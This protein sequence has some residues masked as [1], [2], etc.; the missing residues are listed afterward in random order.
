M[1][2]RPP[3]SLVGEAIL[4]LAVGNA[5]AF[6]G[7]LGDLHEE[8]S[9]SRAAS[10][11][12]RPGA[13]AA[14][15][16]QHAPRP[17]GGLR[18]RRAL[19]A[20]AAG[21]GVDRLRHGSP[22][23]SRRPRDGTTRRRPLAAVGQELGLAARMLRRRPAF[24][25]AVVLTLGLG[26]GAA[27]AVL[28]VAY[29]VWLRPLPFDDPGALVRIYEVK[30][31]D[32]GSV[33]GDGPLR[34]AAL[35]AEVARRSLLSPP[36]V[37]DMR[38]S[39]WD[40]LVSVAAVSSINYDWEHDGTSERL[41]AVHASRGVFDVLG[42]RAI[43]GGFFSD[44]PG[45]REVVLGEGFWRRAFGADPSVV[46]ERTVTLD[47]ERYLIVGVVPDG[48]PYPENGEDLWTPWDPTPDD[49]SEG[50]RGARYLDV[51]GRLRPGAT[52]DGARGELDAFVR[53][54]G[55]EHENHAGWSAT[56]VPLRRDLIR[57][58]LGI[59][60]LLLTAAVLFLFIACANVAGLIAARR[61]SERHEHRLRIALGASRWRVLGH[62]VAEMLLLATV[63]AL[64]AVLLAFWAMAPLRRIAPADIPRIADL[65][66]DGVVLAVL[67]AGV[68][69][70][71]ALI[72]VFSHAVAARGGDTA[73]SRQA[74]AP[75]SGARS[76]LM[77]AQVAV[78][79]LLLLG[80]A[81]LAS[82]FRQLARVDPGFTAEGLMIAPL[83]LS[84]RSYPDDAARLQ[85]FES[86]LAGLARRGHAA[87]LDINPPLAGTTM[88]FGYRAG[89]GTI[90]RSS[91]QH[92]GQ[93]HVV[94]SGY[95][96]VAGIP[97]LTGRDFDAG[98]REGAQPVVIIS[99]ALARAHFDG[100]PVGREMMV[101]S[102]MRRIVGVV[103][104]VSH[105]GPD[106]PPPPEM[107][108]PLAQDPWLLGHILVRPG[109]TF[110][111]NV[112]KEVVAGIDA[113]VPATAM[114]PYEDLLRRWFGPLRFQLVVVA[115]L[116]LAGALLALVGLYALIAFVVA[117][118][119]REIGI[120]VA[121][122]E[123]AL[124]VFA[125]VMARGVALTA[126]GFVLGTL[127]ALA[128]RGVIASLGTA[129]D[130]LDP[131]V[132]AVVAASVAAA[133]L[134]ASAW[135]ARRAAAVDPIEA[136]RAATE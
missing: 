82:H 113:G 49:L 17:A 44:R 83:V 46:G 106:T 30:L 15:T 37:E 53:A 13:S 65:Q 75:G 89:D 35:D 33:A 10:G 104:E 85:F 27:A 120:R 99:E 3:R 29:G 26:F 18:Y 48:L 121:L 39:D 61:V 40:A 132:V 52:I 116:A 71:G 111:P 101:V 31:D 38:R 107:Y 4:R 108:V 47:G 134:V 11:R 130:V 2:R 63:G 127:G 9:R 36:L 68:L 34:P 12:T 98:D 105:F 86:V 66:L 28:S 80:G 50:M 102:T 78:T 56:A 14:R 69:A 73:G 62:E 79:T 59:L 124:S 8:I 87:A 51:I 100:D 57:P 43:A 117:A 16:G 96:G 76:G 109:D 90:D 70:A 125:R 93:Y 131:F 123:T 22:G 45:S 20:L 72:A 42:L 110:S 23:R 41:L 135:P 55:E 54:L 103:G 74:T 112:L 126:T 5:Q 24:S 60:R 91:E 115:L 119:R 6:D 128:L 114:A 67:V 21:Y 81:A 19:L 64:A 92:W 88:R 58:F 95:F 118:R 32:E 97:L 84:Q 136:L 7:L 77:V 1:S 25:A 133:T 122:G 129:V 94:S